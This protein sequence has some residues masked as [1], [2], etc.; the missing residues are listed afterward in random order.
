MWQRICY[1][2]RCFIEEHR[3]EIPSPELHDL[4]LVNIVFESLKETV[5]NGGEEALQNVIINF[6]Y[7][8]KFYNIIF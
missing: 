3:E 5:E 4:R 6:Y 1:D 8:Y 7:I 2:L